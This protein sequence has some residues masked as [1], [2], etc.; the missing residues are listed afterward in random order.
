MN[1]DA[2]FGV[3]HRED[4]AVNSDS[5]ALIPAQLRVASDAIHNRCE[6]GAE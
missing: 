3:F 6:A 4:I 1:Q 2:S 5:P